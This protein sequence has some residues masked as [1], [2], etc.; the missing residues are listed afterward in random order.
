MSQSVFETRTL[1]NIHE[2][3]RQVYLS[4]N[5]PWIIGYSGGK[6]ST[7][8]AQLVWNALSELPTEKL[9]KEIYIISSDTL[10]ESPPI[11][12]RITNSLKNIS[13]AAK[14]SHLPLSTNLLEP[15]LSDTFWVRLLGR[16]YPAPTSMFRWCTDMLKINNA[17][18][19]IQEKVSEYGEVVVL[20][21]Q[22]K[23][24]SSNR[25]Q[26]MEMYK[27]EKSLLSRH[28]KYPQTYVYTPL[29]DFSADDVWN[30]LLQNKNPW[31]EKNRDLLSLYQDANAKECPLVVD[32]NTE[33][34]GTGRFGC[35]TCTVVDQNKALANLIDNGLEWMEPLAEL[36]E[37]LKKTQDP[38]EWKKIREVK[39]RHGGVDLKQHMREKTSE[40]DNKE[41]DSYVEYTPGPYTLEFRKEFLENLL[42]AQ[43][44]VQKNGP[45][46]NMELI[47]EDELHEI[48]RIWR[49]EEG[50]WQESVYQIFEKVMKRKIE[51]V[52][53]D[54][55]G[56]KKDEQDLL[57]I[58]CEKHKVP[59]KLVSKLLNAE[60]ENQGTPRRSKIFGKIKKILSEEWRE[61]VE[62]IL[63]ELR[64]RKSQKENVQFIHPPKEKEV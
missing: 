13:D 2:E 14:K 28:S 3:I 23:S 43:I 6:D 60:F 31:G 32:Q 35:W 57:T 56:F 11:I 50:D 54:L 63:A 33:S 18:R 10:V 45:D 16:G 25:K 22:R 59:V 42:E 27:I 30:Y 9:Q 17:D 44:K 37:I 48:Q 53:N 21:G 38:A 36:R 51:R 24:E 58:V 15:K 4:D 8:M 64:E 52:S 20:L 55:G 46:K 5:R 34:C 7:C 1:D 62:E 49:M 12:E 61:D 19:F 40:S 26:T 47:R 29:E 41:N 39:R